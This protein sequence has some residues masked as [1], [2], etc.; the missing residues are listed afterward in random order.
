MLIL[1]FHWHKLTLSVEHNRV[2]FP[3]LNIRGNQFRSHCGEVNYSRYLADGI[4]N[5]Y[6]HVDF[7][8]LIYTYINYMRYNV[9]VFLSHGF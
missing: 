7:N 6:R 3:V 5:L 1:C 9:L 4:A 8:A 2:I